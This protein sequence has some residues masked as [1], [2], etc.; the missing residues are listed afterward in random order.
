MVAVF[1]TMKPT[2]T[3]NTPTSIDV[4]G[5]PERNYTP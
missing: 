1:E 5:E 4:K 3:K 2:S